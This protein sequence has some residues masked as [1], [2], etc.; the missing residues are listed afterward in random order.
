MPSWHEI[1]NEISRSGSTHDVIRRKYI[2]ELSDKSGRNTIIYY[3]GWL[4]K[5]ELAGTEVNDNDKNGFM[6]VIHQLD[7][8]KGL[9]LI[10][11]T[12]GGEVAATESL[13]DYLK[14]MFGDN[15]RAIVPQLAMSAGTMIACACKEIIMGKHSSLGPVDPQFRGIPAHGIKEEFERAYNEIKK[16]Q[17]KIPIW[18]PILAKYPPAFV[19]E[20]EKAIDWST[21]IV[22]DCLITGM[23]KDEKDA[24]A[25][26]KRIVSEIGDHALT[27]SHSRHLSARRCKEI[28]L[29]IIELEND[30][31]F[32]EKVLSVHHACIHTLS[33]TPAF[34]LIE[35]QNGVA[36]IQISQQ[37]V[38]QT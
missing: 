17:A 34:K 22:T 5:P 11:H 38:V 6:T 21:E 25:K 9:D 8:T 16:D 19:G 35:N 7:R 27:K 14:A 1:L 33:S 31:E 23:F 18:Q 4:Q 3:S 36:F 30:H 20:C 12:P 24:N 10:L 15:I 2:T 28:G 13:I 37:V 32:Q 26:A 29:K